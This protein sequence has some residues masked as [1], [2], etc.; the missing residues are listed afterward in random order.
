VPAP[1]GW[2]GRR[3]GAVYAWH[4]PIVMP[5]ISTVLAKLSLSDWPLIVVMSVLTITASLL[6]DSI[7][8]RFDNA[9]IFRL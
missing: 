3:S 1:L 6:L 7:A 4:T 2:L 9:V 8:R 5:A